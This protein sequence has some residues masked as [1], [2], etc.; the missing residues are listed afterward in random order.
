[1]TA[2]VL[3]LGHDKGDYVPALGNDV[4]HV[5]QCMSSMVSS[6]VRRPVDQTRDVDQFR[7]RSPIASVQFN[8]YRTNVIFGF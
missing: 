8:W 4:L 3:A 6:M 2:L 1:M 5:E 7:E